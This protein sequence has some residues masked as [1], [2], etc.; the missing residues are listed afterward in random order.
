MV[1]LF[2]TSPTTFNPEVKKEQVWTNLIKHELK[3]CERLN[4]VLFSYCNM[5]YLVT[6]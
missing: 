5:T 2:Y 4:A 3:V 1:A 6:I